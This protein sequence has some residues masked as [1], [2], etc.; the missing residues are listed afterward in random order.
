MVVDRSS[1]GLRRL[2]HY[3]GG[4]LPGAAWVSQQHSQERFFAF[5]GDQFVRLG[6]LVD[7]KS[8]RDQ[9]LYVQATF[10]Q[11]LN[12]GFQVST[13]GPAHV[14]DGVILPAF[15]IIRI[16]ASRTVGPRVDQSKLFLVVQLARDVQAH[17]AHG[18]DPRPVSAMT[19]ASSTGSAEGVSAQMITASQPRPREKL[20]AASSAPSRSTASAPIRWLTPLARG[21]KSTPRTR[22]P[23]ASG[24][25]DRQQ[26]QKTQADDR[27]ALAQL[28]FR[29]AKSV[30]GNGAQGG[31]CGGLEIHLL[32]QS[33][34]EILR[35]AGVLGVH[36]VSS[37]GASHALPEA[38]PFQARPQSDD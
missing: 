10:R 19:P 34:Q 13:F 21:S 20:E 8:M 26:A 31:K 1:G 3:P 14:T 35:H 11:Q 22:H 18:D 37:A 7:G 5:S 23:A 30:Q 32:R 38:H 24:N 25:P 16:V 12:E 6:R 29:Q 2:D 17:R 33:R 36:C 28:D 15:F 4:R 9:G 27:H